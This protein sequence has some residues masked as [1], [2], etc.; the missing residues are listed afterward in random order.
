VP[1]RADP[2]IGFI[3]SSA[4]KVEGEA[5]GR[6]TIEGAGT[7]TAQVIAEQLKIACQRQ[8]WI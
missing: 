6:T 5:T 3:V 7:R 4:A 8:G 2:P 1:A